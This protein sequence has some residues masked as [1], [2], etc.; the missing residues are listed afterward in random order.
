MII[1]LKREYDKLEYLGRGPH[2]NYIDR[3][4]SADI[5]LYKTSIDDIYI[6]TEADRSA[7]TILF[8]YEY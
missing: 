8:Y 7:T 2:E 6:I 5:A 4:Y 3:N 1:P